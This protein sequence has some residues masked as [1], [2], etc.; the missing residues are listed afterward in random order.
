MLT[1]LAVSSVLLTSCSWDSPGANRYTGNVPAAVHNYTDIPKPIRDALFKRMEKRQF[2]EVA[3]ITKHKIVGKHE[4]SNLRDMHFGKNTICA[5]VSR[6]KW[7]DS[8]LERALIYCEQNYCVAVP[9]I[10]GNVS[11]ITRLE[12]AAPTSPARSDVSPKPERPEQ[13][14][15][16]GQSFIGGI[17]PIHVDVFPPS[18]DIIIPP[19]SK[20]VPPDIYFPPHFPPS[21]PTPPLPPLP[22]LPPPIPEAPSWLLMLAGLIGIFG[23]KLMKDRRQ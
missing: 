10:C 14:S 1:A 12:K 20:V 11:R 17:T 21:P 9:T 6:D 2:D 7:K 4:Y 3:D 15:L 18:T 23:K 8:A 16:G 22:P 13:N 5:T 19:E